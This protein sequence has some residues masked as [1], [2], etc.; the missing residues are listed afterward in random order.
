[1][2]ERLYHIVVIREDT[3]RKTYLTGYP[4]SHAECCTMLPKVRTANRVW[5]KRL[6]YQLEE[7]SA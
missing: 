1:M 6:R 3:G 5:A 4:M 7:V 2:S